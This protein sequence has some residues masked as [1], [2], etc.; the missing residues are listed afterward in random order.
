MR[1]ETLFVFLLI[2]TLVV[3]LVALYL[4]FRNLQMFHQERMAALEKGAPVPIGHALAPWSPRVYLLR[5][6]LW[7][8]AGV[9]LIVS[10]LGIA[11]ATHRIESAENTLWRAKNL[12]QSLNI[13]AEQ[14]KQIAEKD[15]DAQQNGM[16]SSVALLGLIP[17][18]V[19]LA[20][21]VF[22]YTGD[23]RRADDV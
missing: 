7:S 3:I 14:A 2:A 20:Y 16:P 10:L 22:Y 19:G 8:F 15:R 12:A 1:G 4:R 13:S 21:L 18:A 9:A 23:K 6:L 17:V 11:A 5:G